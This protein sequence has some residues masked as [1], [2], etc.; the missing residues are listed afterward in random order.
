MVDSIKPNDVYVG[1]LYRKIDIFIKG[2]IKGDLFWA[3]T[4]STNQSKTCKEAKDKFCKIHKIKP[5]SV[6]A[7]FAVKKGI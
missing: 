6:K 7:S 1:K 2:D 5:E 3:Y 4:C